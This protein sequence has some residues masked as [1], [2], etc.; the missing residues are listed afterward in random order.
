MY[1]VGTV[2][3]SPGECDFDEQKQREDRKLRQEWNAERNGGYRSLSTAEVTVF[4]T[5][6]GYHREIPQSFL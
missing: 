3:F 4:E 6:V 5:I 1:R 2:R